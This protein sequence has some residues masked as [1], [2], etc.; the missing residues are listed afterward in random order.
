MQRVTGPS[1][2]VRDMRERANMLTEL[3]APSAALSRQI[4]LVLTRLPKEPALLLLQRCDTGNSLER[5]RVLRGRCEKGASSRPANM[6][7]TV[8]RPTAFPTNLRG[9][10]TTLRGWELLVTEWE[11]MPLDILNGAMN[12]QIRTQLLLRGTM[13]H[14]VWRSAVMEHFTGQDDPLKV[15]IDGT[16]V[17]GKEAKGEGQTK[18][19]GKQGKGVPPGAREE[20]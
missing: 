1:Q 14:A 8:L 3:A 19:Q 11:N 6:I 9:F 15:D 17:Q 10:E 7:H 12:R 18:N 5:W 16:T 4:H 2:L 20:T 13:D